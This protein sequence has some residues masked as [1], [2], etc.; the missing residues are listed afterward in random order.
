[1]AEN[2]LATPGSTTTRYLKYHPERKILEIGFQTRKVYHYLK[3]PLHVWK[4]YHKTISTGG[5]S[6]K[7]F[8]AYI[9]D[10]YEFIE[11]A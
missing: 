8:N 6:G 4:N 10:K 1:M 11:I 3:L 2:Y 9:K 5:S 7:F